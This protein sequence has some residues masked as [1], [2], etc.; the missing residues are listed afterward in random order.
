MTTRAF[1]VAERDGGAMAGC[2]YTERRDEGRGYV[3]LLA[4][5][6]AH[7]GSGLGR[8]LMREAERHCRRAGCTEI[9]ITVVNLRTELPPFYRS[10][11]YRER[12][13]APFTDSRATA[14][15]HFIIMGKPLIGA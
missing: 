9:V 8:L 11:G 13:T 10:L 12:G 6:P 1:L 2:V 5:D 15:C 7:Q 3:G 4:V 14:D